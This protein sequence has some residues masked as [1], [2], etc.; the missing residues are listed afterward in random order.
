MADNTPPER[1]KIQPEPKPEA[2]K[3]L[4]RYERLQL[5]AE[6]QIEQI[7]N[8]YEIHSNLIKNGLLFF[9]GCAT[10]IVGIGGY[11][12]FHSLSD[13]E[14][15]ARTT[16]QEQVQSM[17][18]T[19]ASQLA[20]ETNRID[21]VIND[22]FNKENI[23]PLIENKIQTKVDQVT[24]K[25]IEEEIRQQID[26]E[27]EILTNKM[28]N[29]QAELNQAKI[30]SQEVTNVLD[31]AMNIVMTLNNDRAAFFKL[32]QESL[33]KTNRYQLAI[34]EAL[35]TVFDQLAQDD[36]PM[37]KK[38]LNWS[39]CNF[40]PNTNSFDDYLQLMNRMPSPTA[41]AIILE[42]LSAQ[43][44]FS[45]EQK[46]VLYRDVFKTTQSLQILERLCAIVNV[47]A[48]LNL[49]LLG[50]PQY[51]AWLNSQITHFIINDSPESIK[52]KSN[53]KLYLARATAFLA[54]NDF[55]NAIKDYETIIS[56]NPTNAEVLNNCA[57]LLATCPVDSLRDGKKAVI[58]AKKACELDNW[59]N[60]R[61]V[62]TL[63]AASAESGNFDQAINYENQAMNMKGISLTEAEEEKQR[64]SFFEKGLPIH[65]AP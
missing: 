60:W 54:E 5:S 49:N 53:E 19:V 56:S 4:D 51:L 48:H 20:D 14:N 65:E 46:F 45:R 17:T 50:E 18:N 23:E 42:T 40:D 64:L 62:G 28:A 8:A 36:S 16:I 9:A 59:N 34:N 31:L 52:T 63:A 38:T 32:N 30:S 39:A 61:L 1:E 11:F 22:K 55:T 24:A 27:F 37:F 2:S 26:P 33:S 3:E 7:G 57:W 10:V 6:R 15:S 12:F 47:D 13:L 25:I 41:Q 21:T 35:S 43:T 58:Y 29:V 44:R